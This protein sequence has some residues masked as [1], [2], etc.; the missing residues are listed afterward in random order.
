MANEHIPLHCKQRK[1]GLSKGTTTNF[2]L[3]D[4]PAIWDSWEGLRVRL[5]I[6]Y[7]WK[8]FIL[9]SKSVQFW[10]IYCCTMCGEIIIFTSTWHGT[11]HSHFASYYY[12]VLHVWLLW[13]PVLW[14]PLL[15]KP[16]LWKPLLWKPLVSNV[17]SLYH[18]IGGC[19]YKRLR[20]ENTYSNYKLPSIPK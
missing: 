18:H 19:R 17:F 1:A 11:L 20:V 13:K 6:T 8:N 12:E 16:L 9:E 2:D 5:D 3:T 4:F 14:K 7:L 15:W 10:K